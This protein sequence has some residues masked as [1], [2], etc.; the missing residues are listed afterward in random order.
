MDQVDSYSGG[1]GGS[2]T[3]VLSRFSGTRPLGPDGL[4]IT[5]PDTANNGV[6]QVD[7][8]T[9][10][11]VPTFAFFTFNPFNFF[12]TPFERFTLYG[13]ANSEVS[14]AVEVRSEERRAGNEGVSKGRSWWRQEH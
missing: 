4:P 9:G 7:P 6:F 3:G 10:T 12:Q 1:T 5:D 14:D 13:Q 2:G 11:A 8:A